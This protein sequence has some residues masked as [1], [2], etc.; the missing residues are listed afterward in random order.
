[1]D[2]IIN[3]EILDWING[4]KSPK[5]IIDTES[6]FTYDDI[7]DWDG[8]EELATRNLNQIMSKLEHA[9]SDLA[10]PVMLSQLKSQVWNDWSKD[11]RILDVNE[12]V[13]RDY[14]NQ[15]TTNNPLV[16]H[17]QSVKSITEILTSEKTNGFRHLSSV[18]PY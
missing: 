5:N 11:T 7:G 12:H 13:I 14:I 3:E 18:F 17:A 8:E 6:N 9:L 15:I 1:M 2:Y 4:N 10:N 16:A